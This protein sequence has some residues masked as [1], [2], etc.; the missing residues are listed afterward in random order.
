MGFF[1]RKKPVSEEVPKP[2][3]T[4]TASELQSEY[5][6]AYLPEESQFSSPEDLMKVI[7]EETNPPKP[8]EVPAQHPA[9]QQHNPGRQYLSAALPMMST[10]KSAP[11]SFAPVFVKLDKYS[12]IL[13]SLS[14]L[15]TTLTV[16]KNSLITLNQLDQV[17]NENMNLIM[18]AL[19]KVEKKLIAL[20][21]EFLRPSNLQESPVD[22][23]E[24]ESLQG[25]I[26]ELHS[27]IQQLKGEMQQVQ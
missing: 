12:N 25:V 27:Q 15:K 1:G 7:S 3:E 17:R 21:A 22:T 10:Q 24:A 13:K 4:K 5:Q 19:D 16:M 6:N 2:Q 20:D 9:P 23:S 8:Q 18:N 11:Q 26:S 14:E